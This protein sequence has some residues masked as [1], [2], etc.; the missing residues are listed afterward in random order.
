MSL[1]NLERFRQLVMEDEALQARLQ[2][3]PDMESL[4]R[5]AVQLGADNGCDFTTD[6]VRQKIEEEWGQ[7]EISFP[8][9]N[10]VEPE[11]IRY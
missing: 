3:S 7:R 11:G 5:T 9:E 10:I 6:E 2:E 1:E 4:V 8:L